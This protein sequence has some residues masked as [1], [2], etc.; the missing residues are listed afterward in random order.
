[1]DLSRRSQTLWTSKDMGAHVHVPDPLGACNTRSCNGFNAPVTQSRHGREWCKCKPLALRNARTLP[2]SACPR[3]CPPL[4]VQPCNPVTIN[5]AGSSRAKATSQ[6]CK[7]TFDS[8]SR[9][10]HASARL[11]ARCPCPHAAH[12]LIAA[13]IS[14]HPPTHPLGLPLGLPRGPLPIGGEGGECLEGSVSFRPRV[15][16]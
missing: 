15:L 12:T 13:P 9:P 7:H 4:L 14:T 5:Q 10:T 8:P 16:S 11:L 2:R 6:S 3:A 1:M